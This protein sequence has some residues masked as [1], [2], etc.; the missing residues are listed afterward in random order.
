MSELAAELRKLA[1]VEEA[2]S[3]WTGAPAFWIDGREFV[4]FHGDLVEI[5]L[6]RKRISGLDDDRVARRTRTSDWVLV[7]ASERELVLE[8][9]RAALEAN[10]R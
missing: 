7:P 8:L 1:D 10:R 9:A 4:H 3:R 2:S 5:R 6:T